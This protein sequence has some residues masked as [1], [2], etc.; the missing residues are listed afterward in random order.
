MKVNT[1]VTD[2]EILFDARSVIVSKTDLKGK[3][4]YAN[5]AFMNV[6]GFTRDELMGKSHNMVR[7][8]DMPPE[9]FADLWLNIEDDRPWRG[10]VKNRVKNG[11][12]YWVEAYVKP[13]FKNGQKT[14]Y[15]SVRSLPSRENIQAAEALYKKIWDKQVKFPRPLKRI[16]AVNEMG[17]ITAILLSLSILMLFASSILGS[18]SDFY[19]FFVA[20]S[21]VSMV[22]LGIYLYR[23]IFK[24]Y[25]LAIAA[26]VQ[27]DEGHLGR[28]ISSTPN[29]RPD[30]LLMALESIRIHQR[31]V[32]SDVLNCCREI[33][34][35]ID[36]LER[37]HQQ[38]MH[39]FESCHSLSETAAEA[40][41]NISEAVQ[42]LSNAIDETATRSVD[43]RQR[44]TQSGDAMQDSLSVSAHTAAIIHDT[45]RAMNTLKEAIKEVGRFAETIEDISSQTNLLALNVAIEAARAGEYGR[46]AVVA[47]EVR[48]LSVHTAEATV[49]IQEVVEKIVQTTTEVTGQLA[50]SLDKA[51]ESKTLFDNV[52]CNL[53]DVVSA[54]NEISEL[55]EQNA[56]LLKEQTSSIMTISD[57]MIQLR[58][59]SSESSDALVRLSQYESDVNHQAEEL[60]AL[61][62]HFELQHP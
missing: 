8:P 4:T 45:N 14:G 19:G 60:H 33:R 53:Q 62:H 39:S 21:V 32:I 12:F 17:L 23:S 6:C 48:N 18:A 3:I 25:R 26:L 24:S 59:L 31:V 36:D 42:S 10:F 47:D 28:P 61:V 27:L 58:D 37:E 50:S 29:G 38:F 15:M 46:G 1:P 11:D 2:H 57:N 20:A 7:H 13:I 35:R 49:K 16:Q 30:Q 9:A 41:T 43:V 55:F 44:A 56:Y 40:V 52:S 22:C 51:D 34:A 54:M 5:D